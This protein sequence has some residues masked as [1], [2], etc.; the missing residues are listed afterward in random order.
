MGYYWPTMKRDVVEFVK[1]I[2]QLPNTSQFDP[3]SSAE[4]AWHGHTMTLPYLEA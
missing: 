1:K 3:H 4:F 2:P